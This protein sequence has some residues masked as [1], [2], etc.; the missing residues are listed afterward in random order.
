M[1]IYLS[2]DEQ[3]ILDWQWLEPG[4]RNI[5]AVM[6]RYVPRRPG[7]ALD[8]GC[9]T[10]RVTFRLA[11]LGYTVDAVDIELRV[12]EAARRIAAQRGA[13]CTFRVAD[14]AEPAA[15]PA[16]VYD[17]VVCSEVL[18]HIEDYRPLI[19]NMHRALRPGGRLIISVPSDPEK[20][21]VLDTYNDHVRRFARSQIEAD[22]RSYFP[23]V[24]VVVTG[25]PFY[26]LLIRAYLLRLRWSGS[27]HSNAALWRNGSTRLVARLV[28]PFC[29][30]DNL[31][32]FT[33][34]GGQ[35]VAVADKADA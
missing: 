19:A 8:V 15:A 31:F 18:E 1:Q 20:Y 9:G 7:R 28:Y 26:R 34:L 30:F 11:A 3:P 17:L 23:R 6:L 29:R 35:L 2:S 24:R 14:F 27:R 25:F 33:G 13:T 21:S 10:G 5:T 16:E 4:L 32:S 12:I 22:L